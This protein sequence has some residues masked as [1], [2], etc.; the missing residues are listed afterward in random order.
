M[1]TLVPTVNLHTMAS[2]LRRRLP[3][4]LLVL[5]LFSAATVLMLS[6]LP[7]H[8][9]H[10]PTAV[11]RTHTSSGLDMKGTIK[12]E[13]AGTLYNIKDIERYKQQPDQSMNASA[14]DARN[15][16]SR[17]KD[18]LARAPEKDGATLSAGDHTMIDRAVQLRGA[19]LLTSAVSLNDIP[20]GAVAD[21]YYPDAMAV[22]KQLFELGSRDV[23]MLISELKNADPLNVT[24]GPDGFRCPQRPG[25]RLSDPSLPDKERLAKFVAGEPGTWIFYQ[26]LRKAGGTGFCQLA[27]DNLKRGEVPPYYCMIDNRGSLATPP[28]NNPQYT[29]EQ[30]V[31][32][33]FRVTSNE[34]DVFYSSMFDW[35]GAVF[36]TTIRDPVD[37]IY[38]QYRFEHLEHRDGSRE[39]APRKTAKEFYLSQKGWTMGENY[40]LKTFIG[41]EDTIIAKPK[42][43]DFYWTYHKYMNKKITWDMFSKALHNI[44][45]F[46]AIFVTEWL[47][48]S[49]SFILNHTLHWSVPP[50]QV[51]P[52]EVQAKRK[53]KKSSS[54]QDS[55]P[56]EDFAF[57]LKE[58]ALDLLFFKAV[59][60][61]YLERLG[62]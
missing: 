19:N 10:R 2:S 55:M 46:H 53:I 18:V 4:P 61:V 31:K 15:I 24:S 3:I 44:M 60:R 5:L 32:H 12:A 6:S 51:L 47:E 30:M 56:P 57:L 54:A 36:A 14:M 58:N 38:S 33:K 34:W 9:L 35:P 50:K 41:T 17:I 43:G 52:H 42:T 16:K 49:S 62:C 7:D 13:N 27:T 25:S 40:Y 45:R 48:Q 39:G 59:Q 11:N 1:K 37:R 26:H 21:V 29:V 20:N 23:E 8:G 22:V 28:W